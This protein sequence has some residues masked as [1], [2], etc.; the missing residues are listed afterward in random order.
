MTHEEWEN[1]ER[2][3]VNNATKDQLKWM[4]KDRDETIRRLCEENERLKADRDKLLNLL[5]KSASRLTA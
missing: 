3:T 4:V 5:C 2:L 1:G